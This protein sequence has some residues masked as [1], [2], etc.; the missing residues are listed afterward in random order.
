MDTLLKFI[1]IEKLGVSLNQKQEQPAAAEED[2]D[3]EEEAAVA[4]E[5]D[6]TLS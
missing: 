2:F 6:S 5:T 1:T 4:K 3:E